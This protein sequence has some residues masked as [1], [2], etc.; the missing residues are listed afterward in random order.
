MEKKILATKVRSLATVGV[1][2]TL[3]NQMKRVDQ[4]VE[5]DPHP[6]T[7]KHINYYRNPSH[8]GRYRSFKI[9]KKSGGCRVISAPRNKTFRL[10]LRYVNEML[11]A[12]YTP[13]EY[14]MGFA[15]GRS[16]V[17]NA[18]IHL[19]QNY[20]FNTDLKDFFPSVDQARVWARLQIKP[21]GLQRPIAGIIAGLCSVRL[22][23]D[24]GTVRYVLPQGAPTSPILTNMVCDT[25][26]RRLGGV[27]KR[28]G[29]RYS[30]YADDITFSSMHNVYEEG[31]DFRSE[32]R[33]IVEDQ[34]FVINE[35]KTR[36]Q[37]RGARQEVTGLTVGERLNVPQSYVRG[38]RN[39]LYIWRKYGEGEARARF[40]E[41]YMAEKGHLREKCP[42]MILVLEGK[43]C[44]LRMVKGP[45][46]S[47]YRRLSTDFDR[48]LHADE[49]AVEP[50]PSGGERLLAEGLA[51]TA[52]APVDLEA[53]NLDLDQLLNNG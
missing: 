37:K 43:L 2:L 8:D 41:S 13:S 16:V 45:N 38:I 20:V 46:D 14:A 10:I 50:L 1:L 11:K 42:D 44:Y 18:Q 22:E 6:F 17:T 40:E 15:E 29:L 9:P 3:L 12:L 30:R 24:E 53:L 28:F 35:K 23:T 33:R 5:E 34:R 39:L 51:L 19:R 4:G 49:G 32:L 7:L 47:V 52:S 48:L 31:G 36:L 26:D 27:A 25:L 21:L